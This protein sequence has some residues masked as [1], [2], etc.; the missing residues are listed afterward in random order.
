MVW[1]VYKEDVGWRSLL[2]CV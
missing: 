2:R 1:W